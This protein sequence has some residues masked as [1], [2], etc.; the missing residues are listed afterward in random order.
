MIYLD[1]AATTLMKPACVAEAVVSALS[2]IGNSGRGVHGN[3]LTA[4]RV[5]YDRSIIFTMMFP[6][7]LPT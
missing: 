1:N 3:S 7:C 6:F 4:S 5:I 2:S